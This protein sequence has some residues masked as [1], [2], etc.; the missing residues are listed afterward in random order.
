M[1]A[2]T[3]QRAIQGSLRAGQ[4]GAAA[5]LLERAGEVAGELREAS[6]LAEEDLILTVSIEQPAALPAGDSQPVAA[7]TGADLTVETVETQA[8]SY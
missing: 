8:E 2:A 4:F 6:G 5:K 1:V 3:R 7:E